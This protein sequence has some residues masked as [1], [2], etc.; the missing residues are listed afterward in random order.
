MADDLLNVL[1]SEIIEMEDVLKWAQLRQHTRMPLEDFRRAVVEKFAE[2][3]FLV[4]VKCFETSEPGTF[5]FDFEITGRTE[6]KE[7]DF[8]RM[9]HEVTHNLLEDPH[10]ETG[11]IKTPT[12][13][14]RE[15]AHHKHRH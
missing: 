8:D 4:T 9:V 7:F 1:D 12:D 6:R 5:A 13:A 2:I 14:S 10:A 11:F 3:G 15:A